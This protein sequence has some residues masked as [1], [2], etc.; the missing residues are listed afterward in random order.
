MSGESPFCQISV[1][2]YLELP[3]TKA[4]LA[5]ANANLKGKGS[6]SEGNGSVSSVH[7]VQLGEPT[8]SFHTVELNQLGQ[9]LGI[10]PEYDFEG[11]NQQG[12]GGRLKLGERTITKDGMRWQTK[13]AAKDG[14]AELGLEAM[15]G[16]SS[17]QNMLEPRNWAGLLHEFYMKSLS[18]DIGGPV[19]TEYAI[20]SCFACTCT[21][22]ARSEPFGSVFGSFTN[23]KDARANAAME[24][25]K[26]LIEQGLANSEG[27]DVR[28]AKKGKEKLEA[29]RVSNVSSCA[30]KVNEL[31]PLLGLPQPS[32][33]I[34]P[35]ADAPM[36]NILS[37]A[38]YFPDNPLLSGP[39]GMVR[40]IFGK[41]N[42]KDECAREVY[43]V[44]MLIAT[45]KGLFE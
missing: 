26:L 17:I 11:D 27:K 13:R 44:L 9:K 6:K 18:S 30:Q 43:R 36:V 5:A 22:P 15:K 19:Y 16:T 14:L 21:I 10:L 7:P 29:I 24:A 31:C 40:N 23:K 8:S 3:R 12:W 35:N 41:K 25:M 20:G 45:E 4:L 37:G 34:G 1:E 32:Y 33:R 39:V 28:I 38:A 42:A 2:D